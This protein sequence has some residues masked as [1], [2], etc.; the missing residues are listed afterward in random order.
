MSI[1]DHIHDKI[2]QFKQK[3]LEIPT[4]IILGREDY[5]EVRKKAVFGTFISCP[6]SSSAHE[7]ILG[8]KITVSRRNHY[9]RILPKKMKYNYLK[10]SYIFVEEAINHQFASLITGT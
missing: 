8:L 9:I 5:N 7:E 6:I 2:C 4:R 10:R 1:I 3:T